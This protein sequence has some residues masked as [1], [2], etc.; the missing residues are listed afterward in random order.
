MGYL[1]WPYI[2][3]YV[4]RNIFS[5]KLLSLVHERAKLEEEEAFVSFIRCQEK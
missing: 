5:N 1:V 3:F 2:L 4:I